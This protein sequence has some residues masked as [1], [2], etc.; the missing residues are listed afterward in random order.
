MSAVGQNLTTETLDKLF[1]MSGNDSP[2]WK[3][4]GERLGLHL[5]PKIT[6]DDFYKGWLAHDFH[7]SWI[8]LA[9]AL[10]QIQEY[11]HAARSICEKQGNLVVKF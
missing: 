8:K 5:Q 6:A 4:I 9:T 11:K 3:R 2:D 10:K 1:V 7:A